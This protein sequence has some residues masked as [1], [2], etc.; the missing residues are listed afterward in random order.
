MLPLCSLCTFSRGETLDLKPAEVFSTFPVRFSVQNSFVTS[1]FSLLCTH[2]AIWGQFW[3]LNEIS[4]SQMKLSSGREMFKTFQKQSLIVFSSYCV[5]QK[6]KI[7]TPNHQL[8][9]YSQAWLLNFLPVCAPQC[10]HSVSN[11]TC[12][13]SYAEET[14]SG[15]GLAA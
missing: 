12:N 10:S 13:A 7:N 3:I 14:E 4:D 5:C 1:S 6:M 15:H 9:Y 8:Q 11:V 2:N